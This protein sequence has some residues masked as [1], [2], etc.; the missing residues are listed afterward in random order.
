MKY[1]DNGRAIASVVF[2]WP[3]FIATVASTWL[4]WHSIA[5]I[6][7]YGPK[8]KHAKLRDDVVKAPSEK[9]G[10]AATT[11]TGTTN[12]PAIPAP[13]ATYAA[14]AGQHDRNAGANRSYAE[15]NQAYSRV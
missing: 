15:A 4:L 7:L 9:I 1:R 13:E 14:P 5:H 10:D 6:D 2:L 3:G 8:S 11:V 12:E